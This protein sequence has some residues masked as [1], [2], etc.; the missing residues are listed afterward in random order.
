MATIK[1]SQIASNLE[2]LEV[3]CKTISTRLLVQ[4]ALGQYYA[5]NTSANNWDDPRTDVQS[6][7]GSRG[8]LSLYQA[9]LYS[10]QEG[11]E[12]SRLL[13]VTSNSVPDITLPYAFANGS[14]VM[15]GDEGLGYPPTLYPNMTYTKN[16]SSSTAYAF[17]GYPLGLESVLLLGPLAINDSFSLVSLTL[18]I[19]NNTSDTDILGFMT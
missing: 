12:D 1:A 16:G 4:A 13:N 7:L 19:V 2:L 6:A 8:Y 15:L 5:G 11:V 18:P 17:P 14:S 10:R 9:S 3:T